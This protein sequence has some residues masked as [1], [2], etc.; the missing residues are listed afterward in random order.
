MNHSD[1]IAFVGVGRMGANMA[2]RLRD[3]NF[4]VT[5]VYDVHRPAAE[6]LAAELGAGCVAPATLAE[7]T[8]RAGVIITVV[9]DDAAMREIFR[10]GQGDSLLAGDA[11]RQAVRQLRHRFSGCAPRGRG[12]RREGGRPSA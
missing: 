6:A 12:R 4:S 9:T 8:A 3:Q 2:R 10:V 7:V 11:Y 1:T 5:A